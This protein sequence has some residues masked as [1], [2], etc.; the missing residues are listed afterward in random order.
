MSELADAKNKK[1]PGGDVLN[2]DLFK[3][4]SKKAKHRLPDTYDLCSER[5]EWKGLL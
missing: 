5:T 3:P 2:I 1:A 4:E